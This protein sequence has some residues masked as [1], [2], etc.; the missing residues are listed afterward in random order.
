MM[1]PRLTVQERLERAETIT[2][3]EVNDR[4]QPLVRTLPPPEHYPVEALGP[5]REAVE[6]VQRKRQA[7]VAIPA[8][9]ALA[10][11]ALATQGIADVETLGGWRPLSLYALTIAASG[12][13]K[14]SCDSD[15][16]SAMH[17]HEQETEKLYREAR[18]DWAIDHAIWKKKHEG[19]LNAIKGGKADRRE[20]EILGVEPPPPALHNRLVSEPT[21]EGLTRLFAEG[22]P[23]L[24]L[25]SDEGGQFLGG[26]A[27]SQDNRQKTLTALNDLWQGNPIRRTRQGDGTFTLHGRRLSLHLMAQPLVVHALLADSLASDTGFLPRC[28][29]TEPV[30]TI[31]TRFHQNGDLDLVGLEGFTQRLQDILNTGLAM[32]PETRELRPRP[33]YLSYEARQALITYSDQVERLQAKGQPFE[34]IRGYASKSAEQ[35][36]RIAGVITLW[37]DLAAQEV[38]ARAMRDGITLARWYLN[39]ALRLAGQAVVSDRTAK[40]E[41]LRIWMLSDSYPLDWLTVREVVQRGPSRLRESAEARKAIHLLVE[42]G[43]LAPLPEGSELGGSKRREAWRIIPE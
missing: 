23:T 2:L 31:G 43:W 17:S 39:E 32:A 9:S 42:Y 34:A 30:S 12:E 33:L 8:Q 18:K 3:V 21:Y 5:L 10:A 25:F 1:P 26:F 36:A 6:A 4:P 13:R 11:A 29:I 15:L 14:S 35:A 37:G 40:A 27:M 22:Q 19:V 41:A 28:L 7:P 20:L 24:G 16:M 38:P